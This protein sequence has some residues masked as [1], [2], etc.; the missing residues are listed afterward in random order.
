LVLA[1]I[2]MATRDNQSPSKLRAGA[3][4]KSNYQS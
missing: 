1:I 2:P 4:G 3:G